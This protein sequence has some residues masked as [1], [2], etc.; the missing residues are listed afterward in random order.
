[1]NIFSINVGG[2]ASFNCKQFWIRGLSNEFKIDVLGIQETKLTKLDSFIA[3]AFWGN[4]SFDVACSCARG[5]SGGL[6]TLWDPSRFCKSRVFSYDNI[7]FV[8]GYRPSFQNPCYIVN[9]YAPQDRAS[10]KRLWNLI[11]DFMINNSGDYF[12]F[13]DFNS[14]RAVHERFG[15]SFCPL[16]T[17]E[18]NAFITSSGLVDYPLGG[19][20]F[21]R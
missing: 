13:G 10:K 19:R 15:L 20:N 17:N 4:N 7:L 18:F 21:T 1:M 6:L 8:E 3:R 2:G 5:R 9:V 11:S 16:S 14:I 12:I